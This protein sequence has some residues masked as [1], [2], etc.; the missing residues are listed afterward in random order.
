MV[1]DNGIGDYTARLQEIEARARAC[2]GR[3]QEGL[4]P[5]VDPELTVS[6]LRGAGFPRASVER[7]R[8]ADLPAEERAQAIAYLVATW[9]RDSSG[10]Q[11]VYVPME[12]DAPYLFLKFG[13]GIAA[14]GILWNAADSAR[15][16]LAGEDLDMVEAA[17]NVNIRLARS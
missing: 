9:Y 2:I 13:V 16:I 4:E 10:G 7:L 6:N 8:D 17:L 5:L 14:S 3:Y 15:E 1:P 12:V 11:W